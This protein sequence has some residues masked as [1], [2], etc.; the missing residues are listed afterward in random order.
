MKNYE[1]TRIIGKRCKGI[2]S[3]RT[4]IN[5]SALLPQSKFPHNLL[6]FSATPT[7]HRSLLRV[8]QM[9]IQQQHQVLLL[10][11]R[12][13]EAMQP[14][15]MQTVPPI[16]QQPQTKTTLGNA[17]PRQASHE[18]QAITFPVPNRHRP[19]LIAKQRLRLRPP[20]LL[21]PTRL[22]SNHRHLERKMRPRKLTRP[23]KS[24]RCLGRS[25][26]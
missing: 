26:A 3:K 19:P 15:R 16:Y 14:I 12:L 22:P 8:R 5:G 2:L 10:A 6:D 23:R 20:L 11:L 13:R 25:S 9:A 18:A 24:R 7:T 17:I 4:A 21:P 1:E